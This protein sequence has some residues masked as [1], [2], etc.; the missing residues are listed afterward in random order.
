[1]QNDLVAPVLLEPS[2]NRREGDT[3]AEGSAIPEI[4]LDLWRSLLPPGYTA[5][6]DAMAVLSVTAAEPEVSRTCFEEGWDGSRR[7]KPA[8]AFVQKALPLLEELQFREQED[9]KSTETDDADGDSETTMVVPYKTTIK[10]LRRSGIESRKLRAAQRKADKETKRL[11]RDVKEMERVAAETARLVEDLRKQKRELEARGAMYRE[12]ASQLEGDQVGLKRVLTRQTVW[13]FQKYAGIELDTYGRPVSPDQARHKH[14]HRPIELGHSASAIPGY[15]TVL[16]RAA[17]EN[18]LQTYGGFNIDPSLSNHVS[19]RMARHRS[20]RPLP[21]VDGDSDNGLVQQPQQP[22][23]V[24]TDM[25]QTTWLQE[26]RHLRESRGKEPR[27][28]YLIDDEIVYT[29]EQ[30][31]GLVHRYQEDEDVEIPEILLQADG[32]GG[33]DDSIDSCWWERFIDFW[34]KEAHLEFQCR[35]HTAA[36]TFLTRHNQLIEMQGQE[37]PPP[38]PSNRALSDSEDD[39]DDSDS[40]EAAMKRDMQ[41][42]QES[43]KSTSVAVNTGMNSLLQISWPDACAKEIEAI[44]QCFSRQVDASLCDPKGDTDDLQKLSQLLGRLLSQINTPVTPRSSPPR[45]AYTPEIGRFEAFRDRF[46]TKVRDGLMSQKDANALLGILDLHESRLMCARSEQPADR[47]LGLTLD[48][49]CSWASV[50]LGYIKDF[51]RSPH[52]R[53]YLQGCPNRRVSAAVED[54]DP[55]ATRLKR[56]ETLGAVTQQMAKMEGPKGKAPVNGTNSAIKLWS[57]YVHRDSWVP[58]FPICTRQEALEAGDQVTERYNITKPWNYAMGGWMCIRCVQPLTTRDGN[59]ACR[60][61][62]GH[63]RTECA[64]PGSGCFGFHPNRFLEYLALGL[65]HDRSL[66]LQQQQQRQQQQQAHPQHKSRTTLVPGAPSQSGG[67]PHHRRNWDARKR[68]TLF[69]NCIKKIIEGQAPW[70]GVVDE[71]ER[72]IDFDGVVDDVAPLIRDWFY[73]LE[74]PADPRGILGR[75]EAVAEY[76]LKIMLDPSKYLDEQRPHIPQAALEGKHDMRPP[77]EWISDRCPLCGMH[78]QTNY[79]ERCRGLCSGCR[80]WTPIINPQSRLIHQPGP[81]QVFVRQRGAK[82]AVSGTP[83]V[84]PPP[85]PPTSV[86]SLTKRP[87]NPPLPNEKA[88]GSPAK[89]RRALASPVPA[90]A[91]VLGSLFLTPLQRTV[92]TTNT[93][94]KKVTTDRG[95]ETKHACQYNIF[96]NLYNKPAD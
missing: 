58:D 52:N 75:C 57:N 65:P 94:K 14:Q 81:Y 95:H 48:Q 74:L 13:L 12:Q 9:R 29:W 66:F 45:T 35:N 15:Q 80:A 87:R 67:K 60:C 76:Q 26:R 83:P 46:D 20:P 92:S 86:V 61:F 72:G 43:I 40:E 33:P 71:Y 27:S 5:Q 28:E 6:Q 69:R 85:P 47:G 84:S 89:R 93:K 42:V 21:R 54:V 30:L 22:M 59:C 24:T 31:R 56:Y 16:T 19:K 2:C 82:R 37:S 96:F 1:M 8:K 7:L 10:Q 41:R 62:R 50:C 18:R 53:E 79:N 44:R 34:N 77:W 90:R 49:R 64:R 70:F 36:N 39:D 11:E 25:H 55:L 3:D 88:H 63:T 38:P 68:W 4:Q 17:K 23:E 51:L 32:R 91:S 78:K 73:H